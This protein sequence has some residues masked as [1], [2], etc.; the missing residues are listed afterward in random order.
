MEKYYIKNII[1][2]TG[3]DYDSVNIIKKSEKSIVSVV[4]SKKKRKKVYF[5]K[6][7]GKRRSL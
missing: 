1:T 2:G 3:D 4:R 5:K 7:F 6:I